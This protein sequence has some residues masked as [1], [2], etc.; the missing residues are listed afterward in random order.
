MQSCTCFLIFREGVGTFLRN[1][2]S[3]YSRKADT[4]PAVGDGV[5]PSLSNLTSFSEEVIILLLSAMLPDR[6]SI[7]CF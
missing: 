3:T 2:V 5:L 6:A 4:K 1:L 7:G